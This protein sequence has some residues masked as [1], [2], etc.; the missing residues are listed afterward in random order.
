LGDTSIDGRIILRLIFSKRDVGKGT[1]CIYI[2]I[3]VVL[4]KG[5]GGQFSK[6]TVFWSF[7]IWSII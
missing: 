3:C 4:C 6:N 1:I 7:A 5:G 2:R